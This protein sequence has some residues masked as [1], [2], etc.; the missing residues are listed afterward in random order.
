MVVKNLEPERTSKTALHGVEAGYEGRKICLFNLIRST[1][2]RMSSL[3]LGT[4]TIGWHHPEI[5][6]PSGFIICSRSF[7]SFLLARPEVLLGGLLWRME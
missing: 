4:T 2:M 6:S 1:V 3:F 5:S 7:A